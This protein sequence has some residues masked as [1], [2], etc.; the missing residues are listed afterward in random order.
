MRL[1]RSI[2]IA[3]VLFAFTFSVSAG[4]D[5]QVLRL[6]DPALDAPLN[7]I[8]GQQTAVFAGGCFWGI[9]AVFQH[10]NGVI[11]ATSRYA[12]GDSIS[13]HYEMVSSGR[14]GHSES[15]QVLYDPAKISF[16]QLLKVFFSVAHD[17]TQLNRQGP[18]AGPQYRS[19]IFTT[20]LEQNRI[21]RAYVAQL[22][23]AKIYPA[24][25]VTQINPLK[26]FY[27]A[28][29]YHQDYLRRHPAQPYIVIN[30]LPKLEQLQRQF[31]D[32]YR[33]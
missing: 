15:V 17:P 13:A 21:A 14:S 5:E 29:D 27:P 22:D 30:D 8:S 19:A 23:Q 10:V 1:T 11:S 6:P 32:I 7:R 2:L 25:I 3:V 4:R 9:Q 16:G 18:D 31:P 12:G 33:P 20:S 28:E 26:V 24:R